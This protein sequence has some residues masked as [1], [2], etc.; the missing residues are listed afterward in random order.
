MS[1]RVDLR[2]AIRDKVE[3]WPARKPTL[4]GAITAADTIIKLSSTDGIAA[5][6]IIGI[7][8]ETVLVL[9]VS[10][11]NIVVLRGH[12]GTTP[13]SH[14]TGLTASVYPPFGWTDA[15]IN[16]SISA[17]IRY[18]REDPPLWTMQSWDVT[19]PANCRSVDLGNATFGYP[20]G[21]D[22]Q[23][24]VFSV[25]IKDSG[26]PAQ[27][28]PIDNWIQRKSV[29]HLAVF[30][31]AAKTVRLESVVYQPDLT[32]DVTSLDAEDYVDPIVLYSAWHLMENL[33]G[34]RVHFVEYAASINER[35]STPDE[36]L[37]T[38]YSSKN[39]A[40]L[41]KRARYAPIPKRWSRWKGGYPSV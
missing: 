36:L 19:W 6:N 25:K 1:N 21:A 32:D 28:W 39:N 24:F 12:H 37:R 38:V 23:G 30:F 7:E 10:S 18:L 14:T 4:D 15:Q 27:F 26:N 13:A 8:N 34:N 20:R 29:L 33:R 5:K 35:A 16:K 11:P 2:L 41:M 22:A 31:T 17:A 3:S 9:S 40:D